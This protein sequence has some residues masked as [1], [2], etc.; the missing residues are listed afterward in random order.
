MFLAKSLHLLAACLLALFA[1][2][3]NA[4]AMDDLQAQNTLLEKI[5]LLPL[6]APHAWRA[7][8]V[9]SPE[10]NACFYDDSVSGPTHYNYFR[11]Y[12]PTQGRYTQF[13]PIG[14]A[15]GLNPYQYAGSNPL[16]NI[17]P[18]GLDIV[19]VTGGRREATNPFGHSAVGVT[20]A[21]LYS[22]GNGTSLG[23]S[24]TSYVASQSQY[25]NQQITII[26]TSPQQDA[27]ALQ[28]LYGQG[29]KNCVGYVDN[30][31]VRTNS[32]L[33]AAGLRTGATGFP[34]SVARGAAGLPGAQTY[35]VPQGGPI[36]QAVID[37]LRR[38]TPPSVP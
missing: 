29:C 8:A 34:G 23:S 36:P 5:E 1:L 7:Q 2:G 4:R 11:S 30:C 33:E 15:G 21:G 20:G 25:R 26:P 10:E 22:Y 35:T 24:V 14:L 3:A 38:F 32:A 16:S 31:A 19:V 12:Q 13:D 28:N 6:H 27:A 18:N 17:D 9:D 37:A